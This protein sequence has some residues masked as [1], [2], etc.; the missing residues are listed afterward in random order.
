M[1]IR[2]KIVNEKS[3]VKYYSLVRNF[4]V[5]LLLALKQSL[6]CLGKVHKPRIFS[7]DVNPND[8][9]C[10]LDRTILRK[11]NKVC[12]GESNFIPW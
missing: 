10:K 3:L 8:R 1:C 7:N 5:P 12:L 11:Q 9:L 6:V 4:K 2:P